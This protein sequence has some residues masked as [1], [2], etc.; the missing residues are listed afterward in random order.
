MCIS[1]EIRGFLGFLDLIYCIAVADESSATA[2]QG[3]WYD[4]KI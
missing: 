1:G 4:S 2:I 3:P